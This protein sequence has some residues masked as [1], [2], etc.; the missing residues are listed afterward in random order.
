MNSNDMNFFGEEKF[1][2]PTTWTFLDRNFFECLRHVL[3]LKSDNANDSNFEVELFSNTG[4]HKVVEWTPWLVWFFLHSWRWGQ[5]R[6]QRVMHG[7][8]SAPPDVHTLTTAV[9][10]ATHCPDGHN[11]KKWGKKWAL[12]WI[13]AS[14]WI[15]YSVLTLSHSMPLLCRST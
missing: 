13:P 15:W 12:G 8:W 14:S 2:M 7:R 11:S 4:R 9:R 5:Q 6:A 3:H 1:W 10:T